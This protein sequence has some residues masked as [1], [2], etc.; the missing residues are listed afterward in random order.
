MRTRKRRNLP[1]PERTSAHR[2]RATT[3]ATADADDDDDAAGYD[4]YN[5]SSS[6]GTPHYSTR[7]ADVHLHSD[8]PVPVTPAVQ[9]LKT[10]ALNDSHRLTVSLQLY[11]FCCFS[12]IAHILISNEQY[13]LIINIFIFFL[14]LFQPKSFR[15]TCSHCGPP[16]NLFAPEKSHQRPFAVQ[17][18]EF[19]FFVY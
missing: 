3:A 18:A 15:R 19:I 4:D 1:S 13:Y 8:A 16:V 5:S 2:R 11:F 7:S 6:D 10:I 9:S 14:L 17:S 12:T